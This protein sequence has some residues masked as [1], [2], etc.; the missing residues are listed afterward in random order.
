MKKDKRVLRPVVDE[1]NLA[2][3]GVVSIQTRVPRSADRWHHSFTVGERQ[4][5]IEGN[6]PEGRPRGLDTNVLLGIE[7]LF[8][9]AGCPEHN[10]LHTNGYE[11]RDASFLPDNGNNY[12][13]LRESINRLYGVYFKVASG[14]SGSTVRH[15]ETMRILDRMQYWDVGETDSIRE[16]VPEAR[17]GL[18][19]AD[20]FAES[21]RSGFTQA[22]DGRILLGIE[23]PPA[24]AL[25]RLLEA[26][27]YTDD[28]RRLGELTVHLEDWRL[29]CGVSKTP[30]N[31]QLRAFGEAHEELVEQRY[32]REVKISG[33]PRERLLTYI[34]AGQD[35][36]D[37]ALVRLLCA[38]GVSSVMANKLAREAPDR[39]EE[40]LAFVEFQRR[41]PSG[42]KR[43]S[44]LIVDYLTKP[45]KYVWEPPQ[46]ATVVREDVW[47]ERSRQQTTAAEDEAAR[48]AEQENQA[49]LASPPEVQW[50]AAQAT[51]KVWLKNH[52]T[53]R[54]SAR[55]EQA[56][57][58]GEILA[59]Q[60]CKDLV[61][62]NMSLNL[63]TYIEDLR[64]RL[65]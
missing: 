53:A 60:L 10:W 13:R 30:P 38:R 63:Q 59:A 3:L 22:L 51:L 16:L 20:Q 4:V 7:T 1:R 5:R 8:A 29:A 24:R 48:Q 32:L 42:V 47:A 33:K 36:P 25:Y 50:T 55:L 23:Q 62:A 56:C 49:L 45:G 12:K 52:L 65:S 54:E 11:L 37:P 64:R 14:L 28:G 43:E 26:Y 9:A 44:A 46:K 39:V 57:R 2:R 18:K 40:A 19:L 27:R 6:A 31:K 58:A 17:L 21:I 35:D 34:F 41:Q 15:N 61:A